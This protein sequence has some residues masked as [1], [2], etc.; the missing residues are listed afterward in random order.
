MDRKKI[1]FG[2]NG[3]ESSSLM[4][5][6]AEQCCKQL[7]HSFSAFFFASL[8]VWEPLSSFIHILSIAL[9][10]TFTHNLLVSPLTGETGREENNVS[11]LAIGRLMG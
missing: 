3:G 11:M 4:E 1:G 6:Q 10:L 2:E 5:N 8:S 7:N 9:S